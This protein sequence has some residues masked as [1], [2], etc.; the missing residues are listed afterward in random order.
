MPVG[1]ASTVAPDLGL[2]RLPSFCN[3]GC[4]PRGA[5]IPASGSPDCA[6]APG[7][8]CARN[9]T[10]RKIARKI[11]NPR[12]GD[13]GG[14]HSFLRIPMIV[15]QFSCGPSKAIV[16]QIPDS[17]TH[18]FLSDSLHPIVK[19]HTTKLVLRYTLLSY[20]ADG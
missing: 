18:A 19:G 1:A 11:P 6:N 20:S 17:I 16:G 2:A 12:F 15:W 7:T 9:P 13:C 5:I 14:E 8:A 3:R 4:N 10:V